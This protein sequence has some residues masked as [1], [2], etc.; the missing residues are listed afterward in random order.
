MFQILISDKLGQA[1]L[2]RLDQMNDVHYDM[3]SSPTMMP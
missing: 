3:K 1:G 2:E